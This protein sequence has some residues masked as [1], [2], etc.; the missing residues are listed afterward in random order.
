MK[1]KTMSLKMN[2][3]VAASAV[4]VGCGG[5]GG[6]GAASGGAAQA[7][8]PAPAP[9]SVSLITNPAVPAATV[10]PEAIAGFKKLISEREHCGFGKLN[11][12]PQLAV[13]ATG[14][15]DWQLINAFK[16]HYQTTGTPG[17]T[18]VEFSDRYIA[19]GYAAPFVGTDE[20]TSM[21]GSNDK[22]GEGVNGVKR[23]LSAPYHALGLLD[24][25]VDVGI[26]VRNI[27]D[28]G[29][30]K[31]PRVVVQINPAYKV[32]TGPQKPDASVLIRTYPCQGTTGTAYQLVNE[33]PNPIPGR[34]LAANPI[35]Q[36]IMIESPVKD[37]QLVIT[38]ASVIPSGGSQIALLSTLTNASDANGIIKANQAVLMP[39]LPLATSTVHSVSIAGTVNGTS[40]T[41]NFTFTTGN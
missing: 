25:Y 19:A 8:A 17:F 33:T 13:A 20:I 34:D 6:G 30:N 16:G 1:T 28:A 23:L 27:T 32:A 2:C 31:N 4:L 35:G 39:N 22:N 15:A 3:L 14:H 41:R 11:W 9:A 37:A 21:L 26:A 10:D 36:P 18:G 29:S 12:N 5:G 24:G 40:F 7:P 38:S